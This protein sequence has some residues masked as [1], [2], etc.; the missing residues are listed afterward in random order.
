MGP[1]LFVSRHDHLRRVPWIDPPP[2][3]VPAPLRA[4][5][6]HLCPIAIGCFTST[7]D[8]LFQFTLTWA[9]LLTSCRPDAPEER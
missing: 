5:I 9:S 3:H 2:G 6:G 1:P 8:S 4:K 7:L